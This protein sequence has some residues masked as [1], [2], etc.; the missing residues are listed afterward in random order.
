MTKNK[1]CFV[2]GRAIYL[3]K[4]G[5]KYQWIHLV[6]AGTSMEAMRECSGVKEVG[7]RNG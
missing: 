6:N 7:V 1:K 4:V 2:C 5:G 3:R